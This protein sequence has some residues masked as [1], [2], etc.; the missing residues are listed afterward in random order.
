MLNTL[1]SLKDSINKKIKYIENNIINLK[2]EIEEN[3]K[4]LNNINI[5][6]KKFE[7]K[8]KEVNKKVLEKLKTNGFITKSDFIKYFDFSGKVSEAMKKFAC[9]HNPHL[10]YLHSFNCQIDSKIVNLDSNSSFSKIVNILFKKLESYEKYV[11]DDL[12]K[13][14]GVSKEDFINELLK[15][16]QMGYKFKI[17]AEIKKKGDLIRYVHYLRRLF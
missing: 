15:L 4:I 8:E 5:L 1:R 11:I 3:T 14:I 13:E 6:I 7:E 17:D 10:F 16:K 9:R 2:K 12:A